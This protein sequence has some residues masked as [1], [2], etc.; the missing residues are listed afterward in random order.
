M[1]KKLES[2]YKTRYKLLILLCAHKSQKKKTNKRLCPSYVSP[3]R[4]WP[5][6]IVN[7]GRARIYFWISI[8]QVQSVDIA[9]G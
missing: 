8:Y 4:T 2:L 1:E 3:A 5:G 7:K 9:W 6:F